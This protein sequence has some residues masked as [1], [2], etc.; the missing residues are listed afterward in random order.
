M[1]MKTGADWKTEMDLTD[2]LMT[3]CQQSYDR[4]MEI[5]GAGLKTA[6][7]WFAAHQEEIEAKL[8]IK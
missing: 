8:G 5:V 7:E 3:K 2:E 4:T 6:N 1:T